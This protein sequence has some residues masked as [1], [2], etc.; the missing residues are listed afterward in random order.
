MRRRALVA[1]MLGLPSLALAAP[2]GIGFR[3]IRGGSAV[4][5]HVVR[6]RDE[7]PVLVAESEVR[8]TVRLAG[9]TVFR[10]AHDTQ[11]RWQGARLLALTSRLDRNGTPGFCEVRAEGNALLL[12][13]TAGE[14]RL[15]GTAAPLTW[16]RAESL[17]AGVPLFDPR[18]G[19]A[20]APEL[21][22][23]AVAGGTR[24]K[25]I[26]GEGAEVLYDAAGTWI[27]FATTGE[28]GSAVRYERA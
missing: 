6:F 19:E 2:G 25:L 18:R 27:G 15:P 11:E 10:Y 9:F 16:W 4:G 12:R 22:R 23:S 3:V 14:A 21:Q 17:T 13:G 8:I 20:V 28:D 24:V 26:G 7:G 5:T 1:G